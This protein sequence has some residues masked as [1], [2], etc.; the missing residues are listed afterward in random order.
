MFCLVIVAVLLRASATVTSELSINQ[1]SISASIICGCSKIGPNSSPCWITLRNCRTIS[2]NSF[3]EV[4]QSFPVT[5][6]HPIPS[7]SE[8]GS[9]KVSLYGR[10]GNGP[11]LHP[12]PQPTVEPTSLK[13]YKPK[14][15]VV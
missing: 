12:H 9:T 2:L 4:D 8:S 5:S 10:I 6:F 15:R 1:L 3:S 13:V 7:G 11:V 14:S